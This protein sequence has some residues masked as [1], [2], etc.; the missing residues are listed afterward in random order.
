MGGKIIYNIAEFQCESPIIGDTF[1]HIGEW[2]FNWTSKW[3]LYNSY[4]LSTDIKL[5]YSGDGQP[6]VQYTSQSI[7]ANAVNFK[8]NINNFDGADFRVLFTI[9]NGTTCSYQFTIPNSSVIPI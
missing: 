9:D 1:R 8:I 4:G 2:T 7:P 3:D 5:F 6:E